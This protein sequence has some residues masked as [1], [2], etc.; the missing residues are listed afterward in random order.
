MSAESEAL[1]TL[2][3][4]LFSPREFHSFSAFLSMAFAVN[5]LQVWDGVSRWVSTRMSESMMSDRTLAQVGPASDDTVSELE[6]RIG[7]LQSFTERTLNASRNLGL[8][9]AAVVFLLVFAVPA[10]LMMPWW[11]VV[12]IFGL[13]FGMPIY[14]IVIVCINR[15]R[16]KRLSDWL[17]RLDSRSSGAGQA[18]WHGCEEAD[19]GTAADPRSDRA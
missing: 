17:N 19:D 15:V 3:G 12:A 7:N 18:G 13:G 6:R 2:V 11:G 9:M 4:W 14:Y 1:T 8:T 16:S 5:F 10:D